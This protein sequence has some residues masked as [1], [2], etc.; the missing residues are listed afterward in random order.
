M[1]WTAAAQASDVTSRQIVSGPYPEQK[2]LLC[3]IDLLLSVIKLGSIHLSSCGRREPPA[4][5]PSERRSATVMPI[6]TKGI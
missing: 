3:V 5:Q 2:L 1:T 6:V 4:R